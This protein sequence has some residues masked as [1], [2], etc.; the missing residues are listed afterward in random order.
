MRAA[1]A[2]LL[3]SVSLAC[4]PPYRAAR[5]AGPAGD[6][7]QTGVRG[8]AGGERLFWQAWRPAGEVRGVLVV[9]HGLKDHSSRYSGLARKLT[10]A[11]YAVWAFDLR[12]HGRSSGRR[13]AIDSFDQYT[14]D[15]AAFIETV[16][17]REGDRPIFLFGHSMGGAIATLTAIEREPAL[18][19]LILSG[20]ALRLDIWPLTA[21]LTRLSGSLTPSLP[22][23]RLDDDD[24]SSDPAVVAAIGKDPLVHHGGAPV[25]TAAGL[26]GATRRIWAGIDRLTLPILALHGTRDELTSPA[27]SR[28]LVARV[29]SA[30]ATLR[31]YDGFMHDLLREPE[32]DRVAGD[33]RAW[34]D[35]HTGGPAAA[36][37]AAR[38]TAE[39]E[40]LA[41]APWH[42]SESL[43]VGVAGQRVS[44]EGGDLDGTLALA[45]RSRL[46]LGR[47]AAYCLGFDGALG[48]SDAGLVYEAELYPLG[49][50]F[51]LG[52]RGVVALC[53]G[54]GLGGIRGAVPFGWQIPVE[55]WVDLGLGPLRVAGWLEGTTVLDA[56]VRQDGSGI[57]GIDELSAGV[58]I[59]LGGD[60][61]YW[62]TTTAG[63][64]PFVAATFRQLMGADF[65]GLALGMHFWGSD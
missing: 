54:A 6:G 36:F 46:F 65:F 2:L 12:G 15:L 14:A 3:V 8:G 63:Y 45:V 49:A 44:E 28:E 37:A 64:G 29:P 22:F 21:P 53:A 40:R 23:F 62:S 26:I 41:P 33:I 32:G 1:A 10:S 5:P 61:R 56:E 38:P 58:A 48:G 30:D 18:A 20:A 39:D 11:G 27:G 43:H 50:G 13:V 59:R 9:M 60:D 4:G 7:H 57:D 55:A 19:G 51:R 42:P 52:D 47:P 31:L 25:G 35:A 24:F 34:L 16:R 17:A